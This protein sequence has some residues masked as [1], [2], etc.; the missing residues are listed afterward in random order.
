M[1]EGYLEKQLN[2]TVLS[3]STFQILAGSN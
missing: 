2:V 3:D 1:T